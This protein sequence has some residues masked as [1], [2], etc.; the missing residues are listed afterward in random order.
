MFFFGQLLDTA[1]FIEYFEV[2][3]KI[4]KSPK[5]KPL[6]HQVSIP[7]PMGRRKASDVARSSAAAGESY[8]NTILSPLERSCRRDSFVRLRDRKPRYDRTVSVGGNYKA[9]SRVAST[10][11]SVLVQPTVDETCIVRTM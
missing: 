8:D 5:T 6:K 7:S 11:L 4:V 9:A 1:L 2:Y 10:P 3:L